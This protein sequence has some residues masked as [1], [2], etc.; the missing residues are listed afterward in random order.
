[1]QCSSDESRACRSRRQVAHPGGSHV[2]CG[3]AEQVIALLVRLL[4]SWAMDIFLNKAAHGVPA[5]RGR[6]AKGKVLHP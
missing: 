2:A 4:P 3:C 1:M 5:L 6:A